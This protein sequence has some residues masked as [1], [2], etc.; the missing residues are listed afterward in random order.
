[1]STGGE[2][3][4]LWSKS[5]A[6]K[7]EKLNALSN[8]ERWENAKMHVQSHTNRLEALCARCGD[9]RHC[10]TYTA[11]AITICGPCLNLILLEWNL[12]R[13]EMGELIQS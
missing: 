12:R 6:R 7:R 8:S 1:M 13:Q 10:R 3:G 9:K 5:F 4:T 11:E 2:V